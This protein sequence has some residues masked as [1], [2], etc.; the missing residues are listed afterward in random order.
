VQLFRRQLLAAQ[1]L[2][3][4]DEGQALLEYWQLFLD[5]LIVPAPDLFVNLLDARPQYGHVGENELSLDRGHVA[6][7]IDAA[8]RVRHRVVAEEAPPGSARRCSSRRT[9]TRW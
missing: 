3:L 9:E 7:R 8:V 1:R 5:Q 6:Q 2:L 4:L